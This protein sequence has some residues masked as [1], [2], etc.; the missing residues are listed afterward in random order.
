MNIKEVKEAI[1]KDFPISQK[2]NPKMVKVRDIESKTS[3]NDFFDL[4]LAQE[5]HRRI[6]VSKA[7]Q[8]RLQ[9]LRE[10]YRLS[11]GAF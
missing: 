10:K 8:K 1:D 2:G 6:R 4:P 11:T 9:K 5:G 3:H 7:S